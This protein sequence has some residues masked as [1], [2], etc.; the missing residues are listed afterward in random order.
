MTVSGPNPKKGGDD[1]G[2]ESKKEVGDSKGVGEA[3]SAILRISETSSTIPNKIRKYQI[4]Y[5]IQIL[6]MSHLI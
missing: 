1:G 2:E 6:Q 4:Q 5:D 3:L